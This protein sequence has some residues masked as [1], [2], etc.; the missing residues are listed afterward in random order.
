MESMNLDGL[1]VISVDY[2]N[3][4]LPKAVKELRPAVYKDGTDYCAII[5]PDP[6]AGVSGCG[7]TPADALNDWNAKLPERI[8][9]PK[10]D[11][12]LA[13]EMTDALSLRKDDVW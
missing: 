7:A 4:N 8:S 6:Q 12:E 5:G 2:E 11:D 10:P 3:D 9:S 13:Q 1:E